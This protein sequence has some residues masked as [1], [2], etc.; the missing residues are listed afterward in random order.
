LLTVYT[1]AVSR[2]EKHTAVEAEN[3]ERSPEIIGSTIS[4]E[5]RNSLMGSMCSAD[6][7]TYYSE[8]KFPTRKL[9]SLPVASHTN[10]TTDNTA[11]PTSVMEAPYSGLESSTRE[12]PSSPVSY[13]SLEKPVYSNTDFASEGERTS[14]LGISVHGTINTLSEMETAV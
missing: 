7:A 3:E 8:L 13:D 9:P 6:A 4:E 11:S 10:G 12:P 5:P 14:D 1:V 2:L